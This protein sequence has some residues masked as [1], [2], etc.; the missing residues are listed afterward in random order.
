MVRVTRLRSS[1]L[2][3]ILNNKMNKQGAL[4]GIACIVLSVVPVIGI[5]L[6][7]LVIKKYPNDTNANTCAS[8]GIVLAGLVTL[9]MVILLL[10]FLLG[11]PIAWM[12]K[13]FPSPG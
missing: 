3:N 1:V 7:T 2:A 12:I 5:I 10:L 6:N 11:L 4:L 9:A 8:V 13:D